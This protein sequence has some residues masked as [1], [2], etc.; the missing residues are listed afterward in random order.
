MPTA[1]IKKVAKKSGEPVAKI[2]KAWQQ[3]TE[4]AKKKFGANSD[5]IYPYATSIISK[6]YQA[7]SQ[8]FDQQFLQPHQQNNLSQG[9]ILN[10]AEEEE[11][12][13]DYGDTGGAG[14]SSMFNNM[15]SKWGTGELVQYLPQDKGIPQ[16]A[17]NLNKKYNMRHVK[18]SNAPIPDYIQDEK[19]AISVTG[20]DKFLDD[21]VELSGDSDIE[22][23]GKY[24]NDLPDNTSIIQSGGIVI[25]EFNHDSNKGQ[26]YVEAITKK[27]LASLN[28]EAFWINGISITPNDTSGLD[29]IEIEKRNKHTKD[30]YA[31]LVEDDKDILNNPNFKK[32]FGNSKVVDSSGN[33]LVVYHGTKLNFQAFDKSS[34]RS[35]Y[36]YSFGFHF[37]TDPKEAGIYSNNVKSNNNDLI[38]PGANIIQAYLK[39]ENP[40]IIETTQP[41]ASMEADL[42]RYDII[43]KIVNSR[44]TGNPY[45]GVIIKPN[46]SD[47]TAWNII[48]F[49]PNQIKSI[50]NNGDFSDSDNISEAISTTANLQSPAPAVVG[51]THTEYKNPLLNDE[52]EEGK[53]E[54]LNIYYDTNSQ[55]IDSLDEAM[56]YI[57]TAGVNW[58]SAPLPGSMADKTL[59]DLNN[60]LPD[61]IDHKNENNLMQIGLSNRGEVKQVAY[62]NN[63]PFVKEVAFKESQQGNHV[64]D[65]IDIANK[66]V[67][68]QTNELDNDDLEKLLKKSS[69]LAGMLELEINNRI[70]KL[71]ENLEDVE[72]II[73][74]AGNYKKLIKDLVRWHD[75]LHEKIV[76]RQLAGNVLKDDD[77]KKAITREIDRINEEITQ[78]KEV[79]DFI[80]NFEEEG[81][82]FKSAKDEA[83]KVLYSHSIIQENL[84]AGLQYHIDNKIPIFENVYRYGSEYYFKLFKEAKNHLDKLSSTDKAFLKES[85]IGDYGIYENKRVPLDCIMEELTEAEY[86]GKDV[87]LNKPKRGGSKKYY[88]YV[89]DP[90]TGNVKKVSFGDTG[91]LKAKINDPEAR[92]S[93]AARH[94]C[95]TKKDKTKPGY[96]ACR[97]PYF[98]KSL[99]LSDKNRSIWW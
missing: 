33:P 54:I 99:G 60:A 5:K 57:A 93:F 25:G 55:L 28:E 91:G 17:L 89:K 1:F 16:Q 35:N 52:I 88:V 13:E 44:K 40:L 31:A 3:A 74:K 61:V 81:K 77:S 45:D 85:D 32:W 47:I 51:G 15:R 12:T 86:N 56:D 30:E 14:V 41:I 48:V 71:Q 8:Y 53:N 37:T 72:T 73:N 34:I 78:V 79:I 59:D 42:N 10:Y 19:A 87:E 96:W 75:D 92:K 21:I 70:P 4:Q 2:E 39:V 97:L 69:E 18:E 64:A 98:A 46:S 11:I 67:C 82:S 50:Y 22:I 58:G 90:K 95:D 29:A 65:L 83:I 66:T 7:E 9:T 43:K 24:D 26:I 27:H 68:K 38:A 63:V 20:Y 6:R 94:Q 49:E 23:N 62:A 36:D 76:D 80:E 84:Q